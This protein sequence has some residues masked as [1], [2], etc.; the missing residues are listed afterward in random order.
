V[1]SDPGASEK[2]FQ[3][4]DYG[5][6]DGAWEMVVQEYSKRKL[7]VGT[8]KLPALAGLARSF[9]ERFSKQFG[10]T[11]YLA[12]HWSHSIISGLQWETP[13]WQAKSDEM[14]REVPLASEPR[15]VAPS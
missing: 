10:K 14:L 12:G 4:Q 2:I 7:T 13:W 15:Y 6:N 11:E 3:L 8:D 9:H 1:H 5:V